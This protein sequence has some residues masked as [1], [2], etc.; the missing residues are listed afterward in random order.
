MP[1]N[2]STIGFTKTNARGF[3]ERLLSANIRT[4]VDVRLH[5][6]SQLSGFAKSDDLAFF[7]E[8]IAGIKYI[9]SPMLAPT[10]DMLKAFK[11]DKGD[12]TEYEK[13]FMGL[14]AERRIE[15]RL[16]PTFFDNAC[17]LCSEAT[18][19]QCHRRLV[20]EYLNSKWDQSLQVHHL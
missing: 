5:N 18:P 15:E 4:L 8:K 2:I 19:H 1:A 3:F 20:C 17:L 7:L 6:T 11:R 10:D 12:W 14:M 16:K 9:H 13:K